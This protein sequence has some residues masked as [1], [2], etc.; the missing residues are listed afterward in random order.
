MQWVQQAVIM[1]QIFRHNNNRILR[2]NGIDGLKNWIENNTPGNLIDFI[3]C[4]LCDQLNF[5]T[6]SE[7]LPPY[8]I[9][10]CKM[11][12]L[13]YLILSKPIANTQ[14]VNQ[15]PIINDPTMF[16]FTAH[17]QPYHV[18]W[19]RA[20]T[21]ANK[22]KCGHVSPFTVSDTSCKSMLSDRYHG[23]EV[24]NARRGGSIFRG[25][26]PPCVTNTSTAATQRT[27]TSAQF[28]RFDPDLDN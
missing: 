11:R 17:K 23:F 9:M 16:L 18:P 19:D 28:V 26:N 8:P 14:D 22:A 5:I 1:I 12:H 4:C 13:T 25:R 2:V 3:A 7:D 10:F 15:K 27:A 21:D 20:I 24:C 6:A